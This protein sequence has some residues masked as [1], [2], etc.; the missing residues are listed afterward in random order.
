MLN[1]L[2]MNAKNTYKEDHRARSESVRSLVQNAR[3]FND[4]GADP[5]TKTPRRIVQF[6]DDANRL[7]TDVKACIESW[8]TLE[9]VGFDHLLF[10][11]EE[12]REFIERQLGPRH[13]EAYSKCYHPAMQSD[14]FRLCYI[15]VGRRLLRRC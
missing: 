5:G 3:V 11:A 8:Q 10:D 1:V 4:H 9:D 6:W 15:Y 2:Q 7:P 12:A 13:E 14:Y